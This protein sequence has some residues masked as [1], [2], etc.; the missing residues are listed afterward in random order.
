MSLP[1]AEIVVVGLAE[2]GATDP[3]AALTAPH[4]MNIV[5]TA[6]T[7]TM[8]AILPAAVIIPSLAQCHPPVAIV[9]VG[10]AESGETNAT[11]ALPPP[12]YLTTAMFDATVAIITIAIAPTT[13][14]VLVTPMTAFAV[15]D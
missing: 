1:P 14:I 15:V 6:A 5:A 2:G 9:V 13:A 10:L 8:I 12:L 3:T 4:F 7:V 11:S